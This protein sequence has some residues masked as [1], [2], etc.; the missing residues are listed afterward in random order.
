MAALN[1]FYDMKTVDLFLQNVLIQNVHMLEM[2]QR[3]LL[4]GLR[5]KV[6]YFLKGA[7]QYS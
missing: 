1:Y 7:I 2:V 6:Q 3:N 5:Y 4:L